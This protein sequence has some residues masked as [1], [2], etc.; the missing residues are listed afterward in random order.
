MVGPDSLYSVIVTCMEDNGIGKKGCTIQSLHPACFSKEFR[1]KMK[2]IEM[3]TDDLVEYPYL[4]S[5]LVL[6]RVGRIREICEDAEKGNIPVYLCEDETW[7]PALKI[8]LGEDY[9]IFKT[10]KDELASRLDEGYISL[11]K[12]EV[13]YVGK[14]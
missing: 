4:Y 12:G 3:M 14:E 8:H 11:W 7:K 9:P 1:D 5:K 6:E 13:L 2:E 10:T